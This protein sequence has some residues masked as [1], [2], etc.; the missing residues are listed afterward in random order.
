MPAWR[1]P[2]AAGWTAA[3]PPGWSRVF[4]LLLAALAPA[5]LASVSVTDDLG[6]QVTLA[7]PAQRIISLAPHL[8]EQLFAVGAGDRIVGTTDF[9]DHPPA[10]RAIARVARAHSV[11]LER[12]AALQ[13][14]LVV[15]W[16]SGFPPSV[17]EALRRLGVPVFVSE[18]RAL[19][20]IA[21]SMQRL[22]RLAGT[23]AT[24]AATRFR[25]QVAAL[26]AQYAARAPVRVFYQVWSQPLMTLGGR[27]VLNEALRAC[28]GRNVFE[29]LTLPA[30]QVSLEAVLAADPQLIVT[31][32]AGGT[33][34]PALAM[35][36]RFEQMSAVRHRQWVTLDAD[37]INRSGPRL[38]D[39]LAVLCTAIDHAR[40]QARN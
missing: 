37:R 19:D 5:A 40:Q 12:V 31:A 27:H 16:G 6:Q 8:T 18:P 30:P 32:E 2:A 15:L 21:T 1:S 11:D 34:S 10:A 25:A 3:R 17:L 23:D 24:A 14:D 38:A 22:A 7:A 13:P 9:S 20:D 4:P 33:P 29:S 28:G 26:R 39:E 36:A 35:W